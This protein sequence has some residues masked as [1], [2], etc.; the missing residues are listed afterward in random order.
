M[1]SPTAVPLDNEFIISFFRLR[2]ALGYIGFL[3]PLVVKGGA[4][5]IDRLPLLNSISASYHTR[6]R[7]IF[8]GTLVSVGVFLFCYRGPD[9]QDNWLTNIAG[10]CA[11]GIA[12]IATYPAG[13][14]LC[15]F[16]A[17]VLPHHGVYHFAFAVVFFL[18]ISYLAIFRFKKLSRPYI[19]KQ[20]ETRNKV[21][22]ICGIIIL[23]SLVAIALI[24]LYDKLYH[25]DTSIAL[26]ETIA[27]M[28]FG[29]AWLTKGQ[30]LLADKDT[31]ATTTA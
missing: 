30:A 23:L 11:L 8:V 22:V 3:M 17:E 24:N 1:K 31:T 13:K 19:T 21:Y 15:P 20:K 29:V 14:A 7:D 9:K 6:M 26:P 12:L 25:A 4:K 2:Q 27:I 16:I 18:I 10:L 5:Y 28:T